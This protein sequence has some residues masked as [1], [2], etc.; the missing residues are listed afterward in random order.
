MQQW[1]RRFAVAAV[2]A[3]ALAPLVVGF[4][5]LSAP[6]SRA[7][8][9]CPGGQYPDIEMQGSCQP[10]PSFATPCTIFGGESG[11]RDWAGICYTPD[12]VKFWPPGQHP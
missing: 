11:Y 10:L 4:M 6:V 8:N 3:L 5:T 9:R 7:D 1:L 2:S 12:L